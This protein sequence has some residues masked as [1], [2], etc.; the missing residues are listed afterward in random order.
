MSVVKE[1]AGAIATA[2]D[3]QGVAT[4]DNDRNIH[5][6]ATGTQAVKG[7]IGEVNEAAGET[8]RSVGNMLSAVE[9]LTR[10]SETLRSEVDKFLAEVRAA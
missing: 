10:Q 5:Q 8:G 9:E 2:V 6:A 3:E 1:F 7:T 4:Q